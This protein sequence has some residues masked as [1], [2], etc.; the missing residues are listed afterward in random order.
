M[1][2]NPYIAYN[3]LRVAGRTVVASNGSQT[4]PIAEK[5]AAGMPLRDALATTLW[6]LDYEEGPVQYAAHRGG[7][8][9]RRRGGVSGC[10]ARGRF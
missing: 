4:D 5:I 9:S 8:E 10:G 2:K 1:F 6:V 3:C 7:G